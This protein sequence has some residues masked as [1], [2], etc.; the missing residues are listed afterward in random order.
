M[1]Q[2]NRPSVA[3]DF[4]DT[5]RVADTVTAVGR[6]QARFFGNGGSGDVF[7]AG[8]GELL[9]N[10]VLNGAVA[11]GAH[12]R[13]G[14]GGSSA[15]GAANGASAFCPIEQ[16]FGAGGVGGGSAGAGLFDAA[17]QRTVDSVIG[18]P[19]VLGEITTALPKSFLRQLHDNLFSFLLVENISERTKLNLYASVLVKRKVYFLAPFC[20]K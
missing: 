2:K 1:Q 5:L 19:T 13:G 9:T 10:N 12:T 18:L 6:M 17:K 15:V 16:T 4:H 3:S 20:L 14:V 8:T 11:N 7:G